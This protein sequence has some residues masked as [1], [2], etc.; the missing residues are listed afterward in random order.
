MNVETRESV[1]LGM[2]EAEVK[3]LRLIVNDLKK[4]VERRQHDIFMLENRLKRF[5]KCET[6]DELR[7]LRNE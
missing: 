3:Q 4:E 6:I 7:S 5:M 2:R 1:A